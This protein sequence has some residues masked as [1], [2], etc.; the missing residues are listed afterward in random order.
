MI[1]RNIV[2][3]RKRENTRPKNT[4][5]LRN[6]KNEQTKTE[7][8][9]R[10]YAFYY[11]MRFLSEKYGHD[12]VMN[13][14]WKP[15]FIKNGIPE[16]TFIPEMSRDLIKVHHAMIYGAHMLYC[17]QPFDPYLEKIMMDEFYENVMK[18]TDSIISKY[19]LSLKERFAL[20]RYKFIG[21]LDRLSVSP[22][23][24]K[25]WNINFELFGSF[26]NTNTEYCGLFSELESPRCRGDVF[27]FTLKPNM[28]ILIH[29]PYT[30]EWIQ[31]ACEI[32]TILLEK[33]KNTNIWLVIPIWNK[34][35]R[36]G[37]HSD[38]AIIDALKFS[39]Y[40]VKH[41]IENLPFYNGLKQVHLKDDVHVF[42][43]KDNIL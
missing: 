22:E 19:P 30:E 25:E 21:E 40:L 13:W 2:E 32:T 5:T 18:T 36:I 41:S 26:Y 43:F 35:N 17:K 23:K 42:H 33:N 3:Q 6:R 10:E 29:P 9:N 28:N 37:L 16:T 14:Y 34:A 15:N 4:R 11:G 8:L 24:K 39:P 27:H 1:I 38:M 20:F 31:K 7:L 12:K